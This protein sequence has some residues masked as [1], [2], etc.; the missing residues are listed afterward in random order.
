MPRKNAFSKAKYD[1]IKNERY[2]VIIFENGQR[3]FTHGGVA[4]DKA[5]ELVQ[6]HSRMSPY[7]TVLVFNEKELKNPETGRTDLCIERNQ[8]YYERYSQKTRVEATA[9]LDVI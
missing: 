6:L 9:G 3:E 2:F 1:Q 4:A 8:S 5:L 7:K